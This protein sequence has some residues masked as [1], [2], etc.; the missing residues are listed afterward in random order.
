MFVVFSIEELAANWRVVLFM[1][2]L[3]SWSSIPMVYLL[4]FSFSAPSGAMVRIS[5]VEII[6]GAISIITM[7]LLQLLLP[8]MP[9]EHFQG[10]RR[11]NLVKR[12]RRPGLVNCAHV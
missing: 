6:S 7:T 3:Y 11:R 9:G 8:S 10:R 1:F 5:I 2:V 12:C 4:S